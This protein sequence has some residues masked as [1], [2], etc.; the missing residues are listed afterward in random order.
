MKEPFK[1]WVIYNRPP[2]F[3]NNYVARLWVDEQL[4]SEMMI[5]PRLEMI[6]DQL[7]RMGLAKL[8]PMD[9]DDPKIVCTYI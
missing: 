6:E 2:D 9:G 7:R 3:P 1:V 5:C 8:M 4:T